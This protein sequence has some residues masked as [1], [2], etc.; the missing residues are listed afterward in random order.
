L[1]LWG[2]LWVVSN[3]ATDLDIEILA[4]TRTLH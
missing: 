1:C 2:Q 3:V 4:A